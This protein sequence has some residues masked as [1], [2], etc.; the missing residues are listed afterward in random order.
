MYDRGNFFTGDQMA[1]VLQVTSPEVTTPNIRTGVGTGQGAGQVGGAGQVRGPQIPGAQ[2]GPEGEADLSQLSGQIVNF[3]SN[4]A[5]FL[6]RLQGADDIPQQLA[7]LLFRDGSSIL[8]SNDPEVAAAMQDLYETFTMES[9]EELLSYLQS[10]TD[11]Q[12]KFSGDFFTGLRNLINSNISDNYREVIS[13]FLQTYNSY[14][15]GQHMLGQMQTLSQDV[16]SLMLRSYRSDFQDLLGQ[17]NWQAENGDTQ[18]NAKILNDQIIPF[19][20]NYISRTH[21][22]GAV[23]KAAVMFSLYAVKYEEGGKEAL[24]NAFSRMA[25]NGDFRMFFNGS[26]E[27]AL[28]QKLAE[29]KTQDQAS[30]FPQAFSDVLLKGT[31]GRN[32]TGAESIDRYYQVLNSLL[33]NESVYMPILHMLIPFRYQNQNVM[34]EMWVN[35]DAD[36]NNN[37]D[38]K[39]SG[40]GRQVKLFLKFNIEKLGNFDM[41][42]MLKNKDIN[43]QLYVP[44]TVPE[45]PAK[46][47]SAV[48]D[49]LRRNGLT[50][51]VQ[52]SP[53][54]REISPEEV[55]PE[56]VE[57]ERSINVRV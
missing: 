46:I 35:P 14:S 43:M 25:K 56:I 23:R 29:L 47:E 5:S 8:A 53:K 44:D 10:Q 48:R 51:D 45:K 24:M 42:A 26:P 19:L 32:G 21:D 16:S 57:S 39:A 27:D 38:T 1:N 18:A 4:Y 52:M 17:V 15:S 49:I 13:Q 37:T 41:I 36:K 31:Q 20:S 12:V 34:S 50:A 54:V 9:P 55:F 11:G 6:N 28:S 22:Y 3:E 2:V 7:Q 40:E 30:A 33:T